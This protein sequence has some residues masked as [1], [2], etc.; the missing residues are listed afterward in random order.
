MKTRFYTRAKKAGKS[1]KKALLKTDKKIYK[2]KK[3]VEKKLIKAPVVGKPLKKV[4][5]LNN[6]FDNTFPKTGKVID[7]GLISPVN[8]IPL[9]TEAGL[10]IKTLG[11]GALKMKKHLKKKKQK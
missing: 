11:G 9:T 2:I 3:K 8:P 7:Y 5:G 6:H 1:T 10:L 4:F